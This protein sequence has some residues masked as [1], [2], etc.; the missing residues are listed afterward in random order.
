M[1]GSAQVSSYD[2]SCQCGAVTFH[3]KLALSAPFQC[4]CSRCRRLNAVMASVK[5]EDFELLQG[6][7]MLKAYRFNSHTI[8]HQFCT[9]CGVQSFAQGTDGHGNAMFVVNVH[10]LEGAVYDKDAVTHFNG[11]EF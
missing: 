3:A 4:N 6:A 7:D 8:A 10:C 5:G 9:E 11:A 1:S 2:G